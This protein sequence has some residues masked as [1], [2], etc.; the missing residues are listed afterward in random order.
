MSSFSG[1]IGAK[2]LNAELLDVTVCGPT[3]GVG[4][5]SRAEGAV[6]DTREGEDASVAWGPG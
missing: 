5:M 4:E 2:A 1:S 3:F 6:V